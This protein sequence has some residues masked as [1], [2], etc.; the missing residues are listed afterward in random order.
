MWSVGII[1]YYLMSGA[2]PVNL[3]SEESDQR[4]H[5]QQLARL[6]KV[7]GWVLL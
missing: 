6:M 5:K 3:V 2:L 4:L 7:S 1:F